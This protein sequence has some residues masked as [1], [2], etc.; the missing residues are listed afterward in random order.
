[1]DILY[2]IY[3]DESCHLEHDRQ[4]AMV[5]GGIWCADSNRKKIA[6][7]IRQIKKKHDLSPKYEV[8]WNKISRNKLNFYVELVE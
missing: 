2:D 8:K 6:R 3:C 5:L 4:K 1:M 7:Q